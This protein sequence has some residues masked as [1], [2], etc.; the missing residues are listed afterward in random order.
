MSIQNQYP[1]KVK[2]KPTQFWSLVVKIAPLLVIA[3][4]FIFLGSPVYPMDKVITQFASTQVLGWWF[5]SLLI[6]FPFGFGL[7]L[8][9]VTLLLAILFVFVQGKPG[10]LLGYVWL[11]IGCLYLFPLLYLSSGFSGPGRDSGLWS[12]ETKGLVIMGTVFLITGL[13]EVFWD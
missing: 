7:A 13:F 3:Y 1:S 5:S 6:D 12:A 9:S 4:T 11:V 2:E 10:Q 8:W